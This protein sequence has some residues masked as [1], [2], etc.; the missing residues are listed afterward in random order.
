MGIGTT[1]ESDRVEAAFGHLTEASPSFS[2]FQNV[3][4]AGV[5]FILPALLSHGLLKGKDIYGS[6]KKGFYGLASILLLLAYMALSRIKNPEQLKQCKPGELGKILGLD[7]V[8]EAKCLRMKIHEIVSRGK[9]DEFTQALSQQWITDEGCV[10]FYIDGHI[11]VYHGY[12]ANLTKKYVSR[13]KLCLAGTTE[14]WVNN[15]FGL[16]YLMVLGELSE[17]LKEVILGRIIPSLLR[18]TAEI[19]DERKLEAEPDIPRFTL[20]FDREAYEPSFFK[21][22]W[23]KYRI[24]V[25]TYR[26]HVKDTWDEKGFTDYTACVIG[27]DV[28]MRLCEKTVTLGGFSVREIRKLS[29]SGHQ[30]SII[31]TH[32]HISIEEVAG[33]MFSRWSQEN[34]FRYMVQDYDI[35]KMSEYG[36]EE[37]EPDRKVV[38]PSY[39]KLSNTLK[40]LREKQRRLKAKLFEIMEK[41][42]NDEIDVLKNTIQKQSALKE[43]ID[44]Y[45]IKIV[46]T[47]GARNKIPY[48]ITLKDMSEDTRYNKLKTE[49]K[50]F[51]NTIRMIAFRAETAIANLLTPY[52]TKAENE[53]RMIVKEIIKSD[54]DFIPDYNENTLTV[55][56]HSLSTPRANY[57]VKK[58]CETLND[59]ETV[60]PETNLR[61]VYKT[62]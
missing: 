24:A 45:E 52:Y 5:L 37:V 47:I 1:R 21:L 26:K 14:Y 11:Q 38:N 46:E 62:V 53:I 58:L 54:A 44:E 50:L 23:Q 39:R 51:M 7:R 28:S 49:S 2:H 30:T 43:N 33:K 19:I 36:I 10:Y 56:L 42:C 48:Y 8:P 41:N 12:T 55:R 57:A 34:F 60:Y 13:E 31:T 29:E 17:R 22:L 25:I 40:K 9:A 20:I 18:D 6:L 3:C 27:K 4:N 15:E 16:P 32:V 61:L 35:D 59:S